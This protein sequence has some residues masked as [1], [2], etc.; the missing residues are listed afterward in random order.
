LVASTGQHTGRSPKDKFTVRDQNTGPTVWWEA[1]QAMELDTFERLRAAF[2]AHAGD[3]DLFVQDLIGGADPA[4]N[5]PVRVVTEQAWH[6]LFIRNLL[7]R[8][9]LPALDDFLPKM[10]IIN[11][12]S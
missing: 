9:D 5:L 6:S 2:I 4:R 8:P 12:P 7:I 3:R 1:N 10:T 11:L